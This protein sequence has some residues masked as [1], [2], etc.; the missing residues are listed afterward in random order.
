MDGGRTDRILS[1]RPIVLRYARLYAG[2]N[3]TLRDDLI[4]EGWV[5]AVRAVDSHR[6]ETGA[7]L[8]T[9]AAHRIRGAML[10]HLRATRHLVS[11]CARTPDETDPRQSPPLTL[12]YAVDIPSQVSVED[13]AL[14]HVEAQQVL[15]AMDLRTAAIVAE[16]VGLGMPLETVGA[17]HGVTASWICKLTAQVLH[18]VRL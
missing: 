11:G 18:D 13:Q 5:G 17:R 1:L 14:A 8:P 16:R 12:D 4:G 10:D 6:P 7:S 15:A 9:Y 3:P 2:H